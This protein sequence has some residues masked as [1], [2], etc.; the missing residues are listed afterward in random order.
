MD[1]T[2]RPGALAGRVRVPA[3]KSHTIRALI[4]GTLADG[5]SLVRS[6]LDS[7]DTRSCV[8]CCRAL[9]AGITEGA[10]GWRVRG[11]GGRLRVP[12]N[13]IDVGNSGTTLYIAMAAASLAGGFTVF[14]G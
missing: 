11:T 12:E 9:G 6:P 2:I 1:V 8:A 4:I 3:S 13:V 5:E 10:E 7:E 14:T